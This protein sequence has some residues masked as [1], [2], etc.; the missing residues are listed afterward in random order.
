MNCDKDQKPY[1]HFY[2]TRVGVLAT[3]SGTSGAS[4]GEIIRLIGVTPS[5]AL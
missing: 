1:H 2:L 4:A 3:A 5:T